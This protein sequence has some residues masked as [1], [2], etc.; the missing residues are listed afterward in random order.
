[1]DHI[2]WYTGPSKICN[3]KSDEKF[4]K[5]YLNYLIN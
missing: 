2:V 3:E 1:M 5:I 4:E